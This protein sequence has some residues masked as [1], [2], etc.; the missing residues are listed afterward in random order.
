MA[1]RSLLRVEVQ[2]EVTGVVVISCS[3]ELDQS[4]CDELREAIT[5]SFTPDLSTLRVDLTGLTFFDSAGVKCLL[6]CHQSC[7]TLGVGLEIVPSRAV[8]RV[9]D[10]VGFRAATEARVLPPAT[11]TSAAADSQMVTAEEP[12][13]D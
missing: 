8:A 1:T 2:Q 3:G 13:G 6:E 4:N 10:V 5:W 9:L 12:G 11:A 7:A